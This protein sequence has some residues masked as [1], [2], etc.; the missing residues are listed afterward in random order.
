MTSASR[1][2][3]LKI[4]IYNC[5][6][7]DDDRHRQDLLHA[8]D[9]SVS[10]M[11]DLLGALLNIGQLDAGKIVPR[12]TTFQVS[13]LLE[14]LEVEFSHQ[15]RRKGLSFGRRPLARRDLQRPGAARAG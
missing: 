6:T 2:A 7:A 14:R 11:E 10:I 4:L 13:R 9:I 3:T 8:M 1:F 5:M 15:A 12:I